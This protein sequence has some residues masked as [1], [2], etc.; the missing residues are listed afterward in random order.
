MCMCVCVC[1]CVCVS[2][3]V[4]LGPASYKTCLLSGGGRR[5]IKQSAKD[6]WLL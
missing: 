4:P 6:K 5:G 2:L 3:G 1:V